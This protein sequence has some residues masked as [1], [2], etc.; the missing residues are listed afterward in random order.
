MI[1]LKKLIIETLK[2]NNEKLLFKES[3]GREFNQIFNDLFFNNKKFVVNG[4]PVVL[5]NLF[6]LFYNSIFRPELRNGNVKLAAPEEVN[7][8]HSKKLSRQFSLGDELVT[9]INNGFSWF[10]NFRDEDI[11]YKVSGIETQHFE[12][13]VFRLVMEQAK[14]L[15]QKAPADGSETLSHDQQKKKEAQ[16]QSKQ[17]ASTKIEIASN[18]VL[19]PKEPRQPKQPKEPKQTEE[20]PKIP[21]NAS[22]QEFQKPSDDQL[23]NVKTHILRKKKD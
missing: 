9:I 2:M 20:E 3:T 10:V 11:T 4:H 21:T 14:E 7:Q 8:D 17:P 13:I 15:S 23:Q 16:L 6:E 1:N 18:N 22:K 12:Q 5:P 19:A